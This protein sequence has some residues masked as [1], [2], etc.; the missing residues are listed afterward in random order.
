MID[1]K[2][3]LDDRLLKP[4]TSVWIGPPDS[5]FLGTIYRSNI[6]IYCDQS[7]FVQYDVEWWDDKILHREVFHSTD[8]EVADE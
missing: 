6:T 8:V 7:T 2:L 5:R 4:G 3:K 1:C